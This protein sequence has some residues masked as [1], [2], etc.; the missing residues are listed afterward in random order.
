MYAT[1]SKRIYLAGWDVFHPDAEMRGKAMVRLCSQYGHQG[2]YPLDGHP[3]SGSKH[4]QAVWIYRSNTHLIDSCHLVI[5]NLNP[6]RGNEPDSGTAFEAGYAIAKGK[7]VYGYLDDLRTQTERYNA[8]T[9]A[10]GLLIEDYDLPINLMLGVPIT[11]VAGGLKET[12]Q[13]L[14]ATLCE[15]HP[16]Q[17]LTKDKTSVAA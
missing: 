2:I 14:N 11:L 10:N 3:P 7:P 16:A 17:R 4:E 13:R 9:D 1:D 8:K 6:F 15:Q 5:A 12:L